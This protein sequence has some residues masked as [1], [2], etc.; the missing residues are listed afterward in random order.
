MIA[1][2]QGERE[3]RRWGDA[4]AKLG[5][6]VVKLGAKVGDTVVKVGATVGDNVVR[7]GATV[8]TQTQNVIQ[9]TSKRMTKARRRISRWWSGKKP[10]PS[11]RVKRKSRADE[12]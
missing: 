7:L 12:L 8:G 3:T 10:S 6:N 5:D 9:Q 1:I 4:V 11:A 2:L